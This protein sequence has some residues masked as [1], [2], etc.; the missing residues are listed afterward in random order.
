MYLCKCCCHLRQRQVSDH[1]D[2]V[3]SRANEL[4]DA[5]GG[6]TAYFRSPALGAWKADSKVSHDE[7]VVFEVMCQDLDRNWWGSS[8]QELEQRFRQIE[9]VVRGHAS[10]TV[11]SRYGDMRRKAGGNGHK[12]TQR[13][14][15]EEVVRGSYLRFSLR[16]L[17]SFVANLLRAPRC[18]RNLDSHERT[19]RTQREEVVRPAI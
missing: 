2:R 6:I 14:Q 4:T 16:F 9:I 19:Q 12:R 8:R 17:C 13:T 15:R 11:V 3:R 10:G 5:F 1:A 7:I 18:T